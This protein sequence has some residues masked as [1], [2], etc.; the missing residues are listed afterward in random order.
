MQEREKDRRTFQAIGHIPGGA[1]RNMRSGPMMG[2]GMPRAGVI[3]GMPGVGIGAGMP[4]VGIGA[5]MPGV[6]I[7]AGMPGVG[8][9]AGIPGGRMCTGMPGVGVG[10]GFK[11][12]GIGVGMPGVGMGG[13]MSGIGVGAGT[14]VGP[15]VPGAGFG[16]G[17][18]G[19]G[20]AGIGAGGISPEVLA[21]LGID[22]PITNTV[23]VA[24]VSRP[25]S[26]LF[27]VFL[28][29]GICAKRYVFVCRFNQSAV[30]LLASE[31]V[32]LL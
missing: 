20:V 26:L 6:G 13:G 2:G 22:G 21:Q 9:G 27:V 30:V 25:V 31:P 23:F 5:G 17:V 10:A 14:V 16:V 29:L 12:T 11:G 28:T 8:I 24:N 19:A 15:G 1:A 32:L 4:G 7:G 3:P 18:V